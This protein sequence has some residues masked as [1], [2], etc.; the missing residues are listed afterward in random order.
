MMRPFFLSLL[1][2]AALVAAAQPATI[3]LSVKEKSL[4]VALEQIA[5]QCEASLVVDAD[6]SERLE[7]ELTLVVQKAAWA[8][9]SAL[10]RDRHQLTLSV[11]GGQLRVSDTE[12]AWRAGLVLRFYDV[13]PLLRGRTQ[14]PS[15]DL[16]LPEPG[17][18]GS[19]LLAPIADMAPPE[20]GTFTDLIQLLV[21]SA[22]WG[23]SGVSLGEYHG[24]LVITQTPSAHASIQ[25][26]LE[27]W[28]RVAARQ[29][30]ARLWRLDP[31]AAAAG[32]VLTPE[33]W[34]PLIAGRR[35]LAAFVTI[36]G[37]QNHHFSA[38]QRTIVADVDVVQ[39]ALDPIASLF[40]SG[41]V[42]DLQPI[43][44]IDGVLATIRLTASV[45]DPAGT[46]S[47]TDDRGQPLANL[48]TPAAAIDRSRDTRLVPF[49]GGTVF[50]FGERVYGLAFE[51]LQYHQGKPGDPRPAVPAQP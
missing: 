14:Y 35:P 23:R 42:V 15:P 3:D 44:T 41:L 37:E 34:A 4:L 8:D 36:D 26:L 33:R 10:L 7:N 48:D 49:G 43:V 46:W 47:M 31:G 13:R 51:V 40:S 12:K 19:R 39:K 9:I 45:A 18:T 50:T 17:G 22:S 2:V 5:E 1:T 29:V 16:D 38:V 24:S 21:D 32:P 28:E 20:M 25:R 11:D 6:C 27:E 30:V